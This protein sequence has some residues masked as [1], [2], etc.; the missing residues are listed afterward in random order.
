MAYGDTDGCEKKL[1]GVVYGYR[2]RPMAS[3]A[4]PYELMYGMKSRLVSPDGVRGKEEN[5]DKRQ[6]ENVSTISIQTE[7]AI[8]SRAATDDRKVIWF[9]VGDIVLVAHGR[10]LTTKWLAMKSKYYGPCTVAA[11]R[12]PRYVL[13]SESGRRARES[14]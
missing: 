12:H 3:G 10:A 11:A 14:I 5:T 13:E 4:S 2:E 7:V 8:H 1:S 6:L 9:R